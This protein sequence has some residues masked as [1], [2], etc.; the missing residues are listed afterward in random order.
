MKSC[1]VLGVLLCIILLTASCQAS[2]PT[3]AEPGT[4][5]W[6]TGVETCPSSKEYGQLVVK[7][8][9][10]YRSELV[11]TANVIASVPHGAKIELLSSSKNSEGTV[12]IRYQG[13]I[14]YVQNLFVV[15]YDPATGVQPDKSSCL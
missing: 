11:D 7:S 10:L 6:I 14:G 9:N 12:K 5:A 15:Q 3:T 8:V 13:K 2:A 1:V 4:P